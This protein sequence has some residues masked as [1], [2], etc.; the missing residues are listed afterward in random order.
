MT[1]VDQEEMIQAF[2]ANRTNPALGIGVR[3]RRVR[4]RQKDVDARGPKDRIEARG[5]LGIAVMDKVARG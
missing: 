5:E 4:G 1:I 2:F 3:V